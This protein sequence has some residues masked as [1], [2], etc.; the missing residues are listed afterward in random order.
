TQATT[1]A[2]EQ[3]FNAAMFRADAAAAVSSGRLI[4]PLDPSGDDE[5]AALSNAV[6]GHLHAD[7]PS[8]V[9]RPPDEVAARRERKAAEAELRA[10][11]AE[12]VQAERESEALERKWTK[13]G[14]HTD[15]LVQ[16]VQQLEADL[17]RVEEEVHRSVRERDG[18]EA[19][20]AE[21]RGRVED[22]QRAVAAARSALDRL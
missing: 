10:A 4:R 6:A 1:D 20:R 17:A 7:L 3:T 22:A 18:L 12:A 21:L 19:A 13:A 16:R 2:V 15:R 9:E 11:Q 14:E 5:P 8:P